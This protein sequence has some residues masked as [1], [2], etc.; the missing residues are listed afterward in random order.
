MGLAL[1]KMEGAG[2]AYDSQRHLWDYSFA[3]PNG[4]MIAGNAAQRAR[5]MAA[6]KRRGLRPGVFDL[7]V[8]YPRAGFHGMF[9]E[10][11]REKGSVTSEDQNIFAYYMKERDYHC[12]IAKGYAEAVTEVEKYL[13][14]VV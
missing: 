3:I 1:V 2:F 5:Y 14:L 9:L 6:L 12:V 8:A 10:M 13:G 7:M 4:Q 11:K